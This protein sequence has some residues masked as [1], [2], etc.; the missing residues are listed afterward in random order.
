MLGVA[1]QHPYLSYPGTLEPEGA[2]RWEMSINKKCIQHAMAMPI[3]TPKTRH[4]IN[5]MLLE[6]CPIVP[7]YWGSVSEKLECNCNHYNL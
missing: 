5:K 1:Q 6:S 7:A 4:L 2:R 3:T